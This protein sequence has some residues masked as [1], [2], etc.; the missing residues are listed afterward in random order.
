MHIFIYMHIP[1]RKLLSIKSN[2]SDLVCFCLKYNSGKSIKL[3]LLLMPIFASSDC[4]LFLSSLYICPGHGCTAIVK[5]ALFFQPFLLK[6]LN[7]LHN[8]IPL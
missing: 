1:F 5:F 6:V 3:I 8:S 2:F 4:L 7:T